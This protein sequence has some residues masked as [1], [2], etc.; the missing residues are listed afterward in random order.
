MTSIFFWWLQF[1]DRYEKCQ[2]D[3]EQAIKDRD[4]MSNKFKPMLDRSFSAAFF[5]FI[6]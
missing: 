4:A 6:K 3:L 5:L 1:R 2:Y